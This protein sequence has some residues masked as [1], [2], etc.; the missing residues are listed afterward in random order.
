MKRSST[1]TSVA[2]VIVFCQGAFAAWTAPVPVS[3]INTA[4]DEGAPFLSYDGLSLYFSR[5]RVPGH[6]P[7]QI[8][9]ATRSTPYG[10][11]TS[12]QVLNNLSDPANYSWVS[13]DNLRLYYYH[14]S[15]S[16]YYIKMSERA[17][18]ND[19]WLAGID[20]LEL[21]ALGDVANPSLSPDELTIV[22][23]GVNVSGGLGGY[24]IWMGTRSDRYSPFSNFTNL[25]EINSTDWDF[26]PRLSYDGLTLYFSSRR[27]GYSQLYETTRT[28]LDSPFGSPERLSDFDL[29]GGI[30]EYPSI[31]ADGNALYFARLYDASY[32]IYVSYADQ[33]AA[34]IPAPGALLLGGMGVG[35]VSC[36]R[37]RKLIL[38]GHVTIYSRDEVL[39]FSKFTKLFIDLYSLGHALRWGNRATH[40]THFRRMAKQT[41]S[42]SAYRKME[43]TPEDQH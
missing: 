6:Y 26:H 14:S 8:Y 7:S 19:L 33:P 2:I 17:S 34:V 3:E 15:R 30:L 41:P 20:V 37:R 40:P 35:L 28:C 31:S 5:Q 9:S 32:D 1:L 25:S 23:T 21:N 36:L 27:D 39:L 12:E 22:F 43:G 24:D 10:Q 11:F 42:P 16:R 18:V 38:K 13:P 4:Y 29:L